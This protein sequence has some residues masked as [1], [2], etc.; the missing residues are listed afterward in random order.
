MRASSES[1]NGEA[2]E[3][4]EL[5]SEE[6]IAEQSIHAEGMGTL[7]DVANVKAR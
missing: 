3:S 5:T 7:K 2:E 4:S 1:E 6:V